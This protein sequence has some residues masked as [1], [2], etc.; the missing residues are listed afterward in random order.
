MKNFVKH[1]IGKGRQVA[2]LQIV[3]ITCKLED[4][5]KFSYEYDD[6]VRYVSFEVAK[7]KTADNFGRDYT[8]YV[9]VLEES[10]VTKE[11]VPEASTSADDTAQEGQ[12]AAA[13]EECPVLWEVYFRKWKERVTPFLFFLQFGFMKTNMSH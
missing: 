12:S 9:S 7:M 4:L 10:A 6:G 13:K 1:Y 2:D 8:A 11:E 5:Q 3:K